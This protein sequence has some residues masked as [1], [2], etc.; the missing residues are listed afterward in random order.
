MVIDEVK[1]EISKEK[2]KLEKK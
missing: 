2:K 1:K